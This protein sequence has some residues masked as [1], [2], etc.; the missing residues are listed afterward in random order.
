MSLLDVGEKLITLLGV[1]LSGAATSLVSD[2]IRRRGSKNEARSRRREESFSKCLSSIFASEGEVSRLEDLKMQ[3]VIDPG[4]TRANDL[5]Q[6][7]EDTLSVEQATVGPHFQNAARNVIA[8]L[9][10]VAEL[11]AENKVAVVQS[12]PREKLQHELIAAI[13]A[14]V[15]EIVASGQ[16]LK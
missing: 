4:F 11:I 13:P 3:G 14:D 10:Y 5:Q 1:F 8:R 12:D 7:A 9:A 6:T 16:I 2:S 15:R